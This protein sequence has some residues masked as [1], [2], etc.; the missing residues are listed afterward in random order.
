[1]SRYALQFQI[2]KLLNSLQFSKI[3]SEKHFLEM[4]KIVL[5]VSIWSHIVV[6]VR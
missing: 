4:G 2:Y 3:D 1:M 5:K 6:Q